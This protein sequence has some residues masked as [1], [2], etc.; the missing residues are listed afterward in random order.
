MSL[1]NFTISKNL[2]QGAIRDRKVALA[3]ISAKHP[4]PIL[5][6]LKGN[7]IYRP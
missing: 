2:L 3:E 1:S 4:C 5:L 7:V 6:K